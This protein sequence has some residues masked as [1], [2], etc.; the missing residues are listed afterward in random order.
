MRAR[1][2]ALNS[3]RLLVRRVQK[4]NSNA[5]ALVFPDNTIGIVDWG[6][7][8]PISIRSL[9]D[10]V[11]P[12]SMRFVLATHAHADHTLGLRNVLAECHSRRIHIDCLVY[13]SPGVL[14]KSRPSPLWRALLF[15]YEH[16]IT[17][18]E[19]VI[20]Q[21]PN[22]RPG[23]PLP[24]AKS[25]NWEVAVLAPPSTVNTRETCEARPKDVVQ[26]TPRASYCSSATRKAT[27]T[28]A[29]RYCPGTPLPAY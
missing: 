1:A 12:P 23:S 10:E 24:L 22:M 15:A 21:F 28:R 2:S 9:L 5:V 27:I 25:S 7:D 20:H 11:A 13:P 17:Q 29:G 19:A 26:A 16:R 18:V 4:G 3:T 8:D 6:T 14:N